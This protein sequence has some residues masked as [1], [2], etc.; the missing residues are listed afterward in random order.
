MPKQ[1]LH[2]KKNILDPTPTQDAI[3]TNVRE[4]YVRVGDPINLHLPLLHWVA[5]SQVSFNKTKNET[6]QRTDL[7]WAMTLSEDK[8]ALHYV[9]L[10]RF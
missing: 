8:Q 4:K 2:V 1:S 6:D 10:I 5:V 9:Q 3:V 7:V